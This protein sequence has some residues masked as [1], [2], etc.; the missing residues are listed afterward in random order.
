MLRN[1]I[2]NAHKENGQP[3]H[4]DDVPALNRE[5]HAISDIDFL[6]KTGWPKRENIRARG[7]MCIASKLGA[8]D[9]ADGQKLN[10]LNRNNTTYCITVLPNFLHMISNTFC[11]VYFSV[12]CNIWPFLTQGIICPPSL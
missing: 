7:I 11:I 3:Y 4:E 2:L 12:C 9:F 1:I 8:Y 6:T 5:L 10:L